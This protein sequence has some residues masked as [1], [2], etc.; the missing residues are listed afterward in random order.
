MVPILYLILDNDPNPI[1]V[2]LVSL[3]IWLVSF[4]A[5]PTPISTEELYSRFQ[6][7]EELPCRMQK[8][9]LELF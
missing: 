9:E 3:K 8:R 1:S 4:L 7:V 5:E 6:L 2:L